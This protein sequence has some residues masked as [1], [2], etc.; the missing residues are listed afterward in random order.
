[1]IER[2]EAITDATS[3]TGSYVAGI[4]VEAF[5][6]SERDTFAERSRDLVNKIVDEDVK[7]KAQGDRQ[8]D[9]NSKYEYTKEAT[10]VLMPVCHVVFEYNEKTYQL[11]A[12]GA[13]ISRM[14]VDELPRDAERER[15]IR[16]GFLPLG[17]AILASI[18]CALWV[19]GEELKEPF[20]AYL[21]MLCFSAAALIYGVFRRSAL[22]DYS[23]NLRKAVLNF[24]KAS[25]ADVDLLSEQEKSALLNSF[26]RPRRPWITRKDRIVILVPSLLAIVSIVGIT[27]ADILFSDNS[28][29]PQPQPDLRQLCKNAL[30]SDGSDW[31][32]SPRY[33][34]SVQEAI[35]RGLTIASCRQTA[36][37][38]PPSPRAPWPVPPPREEPGNTSKL[39]DGQL[40]RDALN[41]PLT[42][43]DP[44]PAYRGKIEEAKRRGFTIASC[45]QTLGF[46][47]PPTMTPP[48]VPRDIGLQLRQRTAEFLAAL[49]GEASG[50]NNDAL[51]ASNNNYAEQVS[52]F[53]KSYSRQQVIDDLKGEFDRWPI[54][55]Y[56]IQQG[57]VKIECD[58]PA[59][60]C[61]ANGLLDFDSKNLTK[62]QHSWGVATFGYVVRFASLETPPKIIQETGE[63]QVHHLEPFSAPSQPPQATSA[64]ETRCDELAA[65]PNDHA[66]SPNVD[67][68]AYGSLGAQSADAIASCESAIKQYPDQLRFQY[69][70]ARALQTTGDQRS[71]KRASAILKQLV[72]LRYAAAFDNLGWL[73]ID[74]DPA[75]PDYP[76]AVN[77]FR[78]GANSGDPDA[79][80]SL[81][82]MIIKGWTTP[83][84]P[85][86]MPVTL[87]TRAC[88]LGNK[89]ACDELPKIQGGLANQQPNAL[90]QQQ[91][92]ELMR[93]ILGNILQHIG[94]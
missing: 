31:D 20:Y 12:D 21:G 29:L 54:R 83:L 44:N 6:K 32:Q 55:Q 84:N 38:P 75:A 90:T 63:A 27:S 76:S 30:S 42:D 69:Q 66:K 5:Q 37:L 10:S 16:L 8:K 81:A 91:A 41:S 17:A 45:R 39:P 58:E 59:L 24:Q 77:L 56:T 88:Q 26:A 25:T 9:W 89:A 19:S 78:T 60:T 4:E 93:S 82:V 11:W 23:R 62:N 71:R 7:S 48:G 40:C 43:W 18:V 73:N 72:D 74:L 22:L 47:P 70:L 87:I 1:M 33:S 64:P 28:G 34:S 57:S 68:V 15:D 79:I 2:S 52:Y 85:S 14:Q 65:N 49:Y 53:G 50:P 86:E 67:G 13:D 94:R 80:L 46:A 92:Q 51:A 35:R 3:D 36:G 61:T